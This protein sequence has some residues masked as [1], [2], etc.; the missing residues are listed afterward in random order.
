VTAAYRYLKKQ[1]KFPDIASRAAAAAAE[2]AARLQRHQALLQQRYDV[3]RVEFPQQR[4]QIDS[5]IEQ[6]QGCFQLLEEQPQQQ[7]QQQQ[8]QQD[9][10]TPAE[11]PPQQQ[12]DFRERQP[13]QQEAQER[14]P[15]PQEPAATATAADEQWEDVPPPDAAAACGD[16]ADEGEGVGAFGD[17]DMEELVGDYH[18]G[19]ADR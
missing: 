3:F 8:Q 6:I 9:L 2:A 12:Q 19:G 1:Y 13:Q 14:R 16:V 18:T 15:A 7:Q 17:Y 5:L 11:P 4:R 10:Q